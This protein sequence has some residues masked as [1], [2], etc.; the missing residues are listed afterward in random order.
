[1]RLLA[2][3]ILALLVPLPLAA[4]DDDTIVVTGEA[5]PVTVRA[6]HRQARD[7][8]VQQG[9]V[10]D[11]PLARFEDRLC[12][13]V[14]GLTPDIAGLIIDRVRANA[15]MLGVRVQGD[16]CAANFVIVFTPDGE[17]LMRRLMVENPQNFQYLD[18]G[19]KDDILEPGPV[20]VWTS[21]EPRTLTGMPIA[22]VR[23]L[24]RPPTMGVHAAHTRIYTTTRRDIT[25]VMIAFDNEA[26]RNLSVGQLADYATMRGLAQTRPVEGMAIDSILSLFGGTDTPPQRLTNFD[27]AYLNALYADLPNLPAAM[28]LGNVGDELRELT[29]VG[30]ESGD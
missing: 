30:S 4:Q 22:Q 28:K 18:Q 19:K 27:L 7:I 29:R 2:P 26:V 1:M 21:V 25:A 14:T 5:E 3:L 24:T 8:A 11:V 16:G 6:V 13:G 10:Y 9:N 17:A 20:H 15:Q 23:D 12:P